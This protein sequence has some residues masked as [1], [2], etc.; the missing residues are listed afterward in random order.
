MLGLRGVCTFQAALQPDFKA[1][2]KGVKNP[3]GDGH[4]SERIVERLVSI[5]LG[6]S[7]VM[8]RF[9]DMDNESR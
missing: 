8:K 3:Y 6:P 4:A 5:D 2:L 1:G 7:L 9:V